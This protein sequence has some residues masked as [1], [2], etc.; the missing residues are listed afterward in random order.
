MATIFEKISTHIVGRRGDVFLN[1]LLEVPLGRML[2][3]LGIWMC[4]H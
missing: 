4:S 3:I 2:S 1:I